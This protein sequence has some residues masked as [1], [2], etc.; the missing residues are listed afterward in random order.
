MFKP[1]VYVK[2]ES[3]DPIFRSTNRDFV[4]RSKV[5]PMVLFVLGILIMTT[6]V[7]IPVILIKENDEVTTPVTSSVLGIASGF[8]DFEF[9]E[10]S[11]ESNETTEEVIRAEPVPKTFFLDIPKLGIE[12]AVV[13]TNSPSLNPDTMLGHYAGSS[14][15]GNV[16]NTF[17]YGHSVL[18]WFYNPRNYKS[19]F[20][21]LDT[22]VI[23]D[24]FYIKYNEQTLKYKVNKIQ[25]LIPSEVDPLANVSP[26]FLNESTATLMT[27]APPGTKIKRLLVSGVLI[28]EP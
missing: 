8:R 18:R 25:Y 3:F 23:G 20:S 24:A 11:E 4:M 13:E 26:R 2:D 17:I 19:I 10:L 27:C 7:V 28:S 21:T 22:L 12:N 9:S 6:Q 5:Y 14:L 15:P 16:G 1:K